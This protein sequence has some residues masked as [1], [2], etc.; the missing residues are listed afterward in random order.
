MRSWPLVR[1]KLEKRRLGGEAT[2]SMWASALAMLV[3]QVGVQLATGNRGLVQEKGLG[4]CEEFR[5][6]NIQTAAE[7]KGIRWGPCW[8]QWSGQRGSRSDLGREREGQLQRCQ[9]VVLEIQ[10]KEEI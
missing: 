8:G 6:W 4:P 1:R 7:A 9:A 2:S 10:R 3:S 5:T